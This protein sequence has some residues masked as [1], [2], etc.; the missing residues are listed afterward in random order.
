MLYIINICGDTFMIH[1]HTSSGSVQAKE[2][3]GWISLGKSA[4][5]GCFFPMV[6]KGEGPVI[7]SLDILRPIEWGTGCW[8]VLVVWIH[9][10]LK[11]PPKSARSRM[12]D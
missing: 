3:N 10:G 4:N 7:V 2:L 11:S 6:K 1:L 12:M 8:S 9:F 5:H